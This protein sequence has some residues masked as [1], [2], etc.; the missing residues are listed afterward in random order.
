LKPIGSG[1]ESALPSAV[2]SETFHDAGEGL[3]HALCR[4]L[5]EVLERVQ[6]PGAEVDRSVGDREQPAVAGHQIVAVP[7]VH[8]HLEPRPGSAIDPVIP[9]RGDAEWARSVAPDAGAG[10]GPRGRAVRRQHVTGAHLDLL[11]VLADDRPGDP[12]VGEDGPEDLRSF[13]QERAR[14]L[15]AAGKEL[16]EV[17]ARAH[18]AVVGEVVEL[19]PGKLERRSAR[20]D[21]EAVDALESRIERID[22]HPLQGEDSPG[23]E[24][25][26]AHL[27]PGERGLL[28]HEDVDALPGEVVGGRG[29][30]G[31][32][33]DNEDVHLSRSGARDKTRS[34]G[35]SR[36]RSGAHAA[37]GLPTRL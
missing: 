14:L 9:A 15:G 19:R 32:G 16:V 29:A 18:Q 25:V 17:A 21:P 10:A 3:E 5:L 27:L 6:Q 11:V 30:A 34:R 31:A 13:P 12:P 22:P 20:V 2:S 1:P 28:R 26:A 24:P 36:A 35:G 7:E 33:A 4:Q 37:T 8:P 23:G